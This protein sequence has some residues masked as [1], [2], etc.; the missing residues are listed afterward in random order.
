MLDNPEEFY[1]HYYRYY[2]RRLAPQIDVR[3][4]IA[5]VLIVTSAIQYYTS[6]YRWVTQQ[7]LPYVPRY[8]SR[9]FL[10]SL[11]RS[12]VRLG[13]KVPRHSA[14]VPYPSHWHCSEGGHPAGLQGQEEKRSKEPLQRRVETRGRRGHTEDHRGEDGHPVSETNNNLVKVHA[15]KFDRYYEFVFVDSGGYAKPTWKDILIVQL[16]FLPYTI[17]KW[18]Q[19]QAKW[20]WKFTIMGEPL[21]EAEKLHLIRRYMGKSSS[22]FD[23]RFPSSQN[24]II[25]E[26]Q[27]LVP[28]DNF[29]PQL[30]L[31]AM[32]FRVAILPI[33]DFSD[34]ICLLSTHPKM[35]STPLLNRKSRFKICRKNHGQGITII[36]I[37]SVV[38][39]RPSLR[40]L[41]FSLFHF[42]LWPRL[43]GMLIS[44]RSCTFGRT[45]R[46]VLHFLST[47]ETVSWTMIHY[48][49]CF[50]SLSLSGL[51]RGGGGGGT[52]EAR[53]KRPLQILPPLHE[54]GRPW[55]YNVW[56]WLN[57][58][59][60]CVVRLVW[61]SLRPVIFLICYSFL[62][63][64]T[65][66]MQ[67]PTE[68]CHFRASRTN[69]YWLLSLVLEEVPNV[70]TYER[71]QQKISRFF[72]QENMHLTLLSNIE[73]P[74]IQNSTRVF[75]SQLR[76]NKADRSRNLILFLF[77][78]LVVF[79]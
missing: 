42:R 8:D 72:I 7:D 20:L 25:W 12:Q 28:I 40:Y 51:A 66:D 43:N 1:E 50:L 6:W 30:Q 54:E 41:T 3:L 79:S 14:K 74:V 2:K 11:R 61:N 44:K 32:L 35:N 39:Q 9:L 76:F 37:I 38:Q 75:P 24:K 16:V 68:L 64:S 45:S 78:H 71:C 23:V 52:Q 5:V 33:P 63:A 47:V 70:P 49:Y 56:W 34:A 27:S 53:R 15:T 19:F 58:N 48:T 65:F 67:L 17:G 69:V 57:N 22:E 4:V 18:V 73:R 29:K 46:F 10:R 21:G 13:H 59:Q 36:F 62:S 55:S 31:D 26:L 60:V 77:A